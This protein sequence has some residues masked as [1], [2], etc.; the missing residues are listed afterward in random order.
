M[1][2]PVGIGAAVGFIGLAGLVNFVMEKSGSIAV[3]VF[4]G[5]ILECCPTLERSKR[6]SAK[7]GKRSCFGDVHQLFCFAGILLLLQYG[8]RL[9]VVPNIP[10]YLFCGVAWGLSVVVPA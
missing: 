4:A 2:I 7:A 3:Q 9:R 6:K 5:L 8:N 10:W 1:V